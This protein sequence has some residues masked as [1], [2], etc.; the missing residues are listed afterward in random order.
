MKAADPAAVS[1]VG[2]QTSNSRTTGSG[3]S[4]H[5]RPA[6]TINSMARYLDAGTGPRPAHAAGRILDRVCRKI[7][8]RIENRG[9]N[10]PT[11]LR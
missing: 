2:I 1:Q 10:I 9:P 6:A 5:T 3:T 4:L 11:C 7:A 8:L